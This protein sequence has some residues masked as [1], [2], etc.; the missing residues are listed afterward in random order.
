[1]LSKSCGGP[2]TLQRRAT[3]CFVSVV[4]LML[5]ARFG[6]SF[7]PSGLRELQCV[8]SD[9]S[10]K[11]SEHLLEVFTN[12]AA[13]NNFTWWADYGMLLGG[14]RNGHLLPWDKDMDAAFRHEDLDQFLKL[15]TKLKPLGFGIHGVTVCYLEDIPRMDLESELIVS[16]LEM[17][18]Y[19][20]SD[21]GLL[22]RSD[23]KK[24]AD[25]HSVYGWAFWKAVEFTMTSTINRYDEV[26]PLDQVTIHHFKTNPDDTS[27]W[28]VTIPAPMN[29][30]LYL[31]KL[32]G[33]SWKKEVKWKLTCYM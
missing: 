6:L 25:D 5:L 19:V 16:R 30:P 32:Y 20:T 1:M 11:R 8:N 31:E 13:D 22:I 18:P 28:K 15:E 3:Y 29:P 27:Q 12:V 21:T 17:F 24:A 33:K 7:L 26:F 9:E 2:R 23:L 10:M 4:V 14:V